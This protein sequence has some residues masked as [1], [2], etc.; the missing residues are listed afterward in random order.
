MKKCINFFVLCA[1][2]L[3]FVVP[4]ALASDKDLTKEDLKTDKDK[5]SYAIGISVGSNIKKDDLDINL[6][7]LFKGLEDIL[8]K[9]KEPLLSQD[10][11]RT[12]FQA[13]QKKIRE[14]RLE[15][16]KKQ[17]EENKTK[18]TSFLE[19]N[20]KK[21]GVV[22]LENGI[23]YEVLKKGTGESPK[24]T[25]IVECHYKGTTIDG[26]E[27]DSSLKRKEPAKFSLNRVIKGW[28]EAIPK[29]KVGSKWKIVIPAE[30]AYGDRGYGAD[31]PPGSTLI[32]EIELLGFEAPK[33]KKPEEVN[34]KETNIKVEE[35]KKATN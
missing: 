35:E 9:N 12:I 11:M 2:T 22:T 29:M 24:A 34:K 25:D 8:V 21:K 27:F 10:E 19:E 32:F 13:H 23:Q 26:K 20:K 3:L 4:V 33:E 31:I 28:Q 5:I 30:L 1:V 7:L 6:D 18:G 17:S 14:Q 15:Q 16:M